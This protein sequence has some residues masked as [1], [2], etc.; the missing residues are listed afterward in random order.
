MANLGDNIKI[1]ECDAGTCPL[2]FTWG[3]LGCISLFL[4]CCIFPWIILLAFTRTKN[5]K[6]K[7]N[8]ELHVKTD[9]VVQ[10]TLCPKC[11][12]GKINYSRLHNGNT[13]CCGNSSN[14]IFICLNCKTVYPENYLI[15]YFGPNP[16]WRWRESSSQ[17]NAHSSNTHRINTHCQINPHATHA[18]CHA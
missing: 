4:A 7:I 6:Y 10:G 3:F 12:V 5:N 2:G 16:Q 17:I 14:E 8:P 11:Q 9:W 18:H 15:M 1:V 13:D